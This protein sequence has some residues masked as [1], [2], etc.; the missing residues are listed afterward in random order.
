MG[1]TRPFNYEPSRSPRS[2]YRPWQS[3]QFQ[4]WERPNV[5]GSQWCCWLN[6]LTNSP[7]RR[8]ISTI[9]DTLP[10][11]PPTKASPADLT[12]TTLICL[13]SWSVH[14]WRRLTHHAVF[15]NQYNAWRK[16]TCIFFSVK[17]KLIKI[18]DNVAENYP[19][20]CHNFGYTCWTCNLRVYISASKLTR[21][22]PC[23]EGRNLRCSNP[24]V[25][26]SQGFGSGYRVGYTQPTQK[27]NNDKS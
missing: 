5:R 17:S 8:N 24:R 3:H 13:L 16:L 7:C 25:W 4:W 1:W 15:S 6:C 19:H 9:G 27:S 22:D 11:Q 14:A 12:I 26:I 21:R 2:Y 18:P 10:L 23:W 20:I